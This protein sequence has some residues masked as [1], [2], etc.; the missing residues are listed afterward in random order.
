MLFWQTRR[1]RLLSVAALAF[2][3]GIGITSCSNPAIDETNP[4]TL[5]KEAEDDIKND[6][7]QIAID[8][9]RIVKN[10]FPYSKFA[11]EAHLRMGD[12]QYMEE[13]FAE[14]AVT[15]ETFRDLHPK[16]ERIAYALY[17]IGKSYYSEIP[18]TIAR[19]MS[20][21]LK[22]QEAYGDYL[23][24]FPKDAQA[25]E[26]RKEQEEVRAKLA[27]KELYIAN[28]YSKRD[29]HESAKPRYQK[30]LQLYPE[31]VS[32]KEAREKLE[33][34]RKLPPKEPDPDDRPFRKVPE[35]L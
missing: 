27:E 17:R 29:F 11:A 19:D 15:Y 10:K 6:H 7:Y 14:A 32:A 5:M 33:M 25:E 13:S 18:G 3:L 30:I 22:A 21:A 35:S 26:A 24:R 12:V 34:I 9:L 2:A 1:A 31:T 4:E 20:P 16:H 28:Y 23:T 8:K